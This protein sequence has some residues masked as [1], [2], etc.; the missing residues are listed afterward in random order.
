[1]AKKS[2]HMTFVLIRETEHPIKQLRLASWQLRAL[3]FAGIGLLIGLASLATLGWLGIEDTLYLRDLAEENARLESELQIVSNKVGNLESTLREV[4]EYHR[5]TRSLA[6][7]DPIESGALVG[8][9]G[10]P[11]HEPLVTQAAGVDH[12]LDRLSARALVLRQSAEEVL[13]A[14]EVDQERLSR[15]PSIRPIIGGRVSSRYG[16]RVDPFTGRP[17]FH[18]GID[19]SARRGTPIMA[20][21]DGRVKK[22]QRSSGG[23]G[24]LLVIDHG[25]GYETRYAH[26][27]RILVHK[28]Q[29]VARG[30]LIATVG[31]SGH[32]TAP[33]LHYE[34]SKGKKSANPS[35]FILSG[36]FIV[37]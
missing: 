13:E 11:V 17:A 9:V 27:D 14:I 34:V 1:M 33:H 3:L 16:R 35:Q 29:K 15:L 26:C 20:T 4:D 23:Y 28:G 6:N 8:G 12:R 31:S 22:L 19:L 7:L 21:A 18:H 37:D 32:S 5:W 36:E 24:N 10:G 2:K 25:N 30:E